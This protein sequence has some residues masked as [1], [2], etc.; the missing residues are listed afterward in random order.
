MRRLKLGLA[1]ASL[2]ASLFV[3]STARAQSP[4]E[5]SAARQLFVDGLADEEQG[6]FAAALE[7]F[8]RVQRVRDTVPVRYRLGSSL[9]GLGKI[10]LSVEAYTSAVQLG[11]SSGAEPEVVKA[12]QARL[13]A[14]TP[15]LAHVTLSVAPRFSADAEVAIDG[16]RVAPKSFADLPLDAG[17]HVVTATAKGADPFRTQVTVSERGRLEIPI[18]LEPT[19]PPVLPPA[20][21]PSSLPTIGIVTS[22]AGGVLVV[23]GLVFLALRSS[24]ISELNEACPGGKCAADRE[25]ELRDTR[26]R[27]LWQ[28][29]VGATLI[30]AGAVGIGTGLLLFGI[31]G[32]DKKQAARLVPAPTSHGAMLTVAGGF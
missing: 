31:G 19:P 25:Q 14:L 27:A 22:V 16:E 28:G 10:V 5:L 4:E 12:A 6:R 8:K 20:E 1:T 2:A 30:I 23:G 7:K 18:A 3:G 15:R 13:D 24:A 17:T 29:P 21:T 32:Q 11:T 9:E 26:D